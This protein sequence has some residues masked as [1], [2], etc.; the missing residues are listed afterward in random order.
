[1]RRRV[2]VTGVGVVSPVGNDVGTFH[3]NLMEGRSGVAFLE[4]FS[5]EKL[6]SDIGAQV[7]DFDPL[8][9]LTRKESEIYGRVTHF[10]IAA[11]AEAMTMAGIAEV[12]RTPM[13]LDGDGDAD[14]TGPIVGS[15]GIDRTRMGCL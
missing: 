8:R 2:V 13:D 5:T 7:K 14:E 9:F 11:M 4:G 15:D 1:M 6:R 12:P 3:R 10:S